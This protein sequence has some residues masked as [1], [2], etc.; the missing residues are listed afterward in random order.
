[1]GDACIEFDDCFFNCLDK[2][3]MKH[4]LDVSFHGGGGDVFEINCSE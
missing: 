1:M 4:R 2:Q 3:G